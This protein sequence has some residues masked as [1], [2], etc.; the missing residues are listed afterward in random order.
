[1]KKIYFLILALCVF[2]GITAQIVTIPDANFKAILLSAN[3]S[4]VV[5]GYNYMQGIQLDANNNGEIEI[6]EAAEIQY[7]DVSNSNISDLTG[8]QSFVNLRQIICSNNNLTS[9]DLS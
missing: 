2:N 5:A 1:M 7:L 9:I 6:S 8:V 3:T 4:N